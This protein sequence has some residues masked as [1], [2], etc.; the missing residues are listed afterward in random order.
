VV[1]K[2]IGVR[3][4]QTNRFPDRFNLKLPAGLAHALGELAARQRTTMSEVVRQ[5]L[6]REVESAGVSLGEP[7]PRVP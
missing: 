1:P 6:I 5:T 4:N 3:E 7:E 2:E